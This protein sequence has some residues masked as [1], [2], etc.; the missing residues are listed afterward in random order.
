VAAI[1]QAN[2]LSLACRQIVVGEGSAA[3]LARQSAGRACACAGRHL[4]RLP[5]KPLCGVLCSLLLCASSL[6]AYSRL[7]CLSVSPTVPPFLAIS[8]LPAARTTSAAR[9]APRACTARCLR[10]LPLLAGLDLY[11]AGAPLTRLAAP[12]N[13]IRALLYTPRIHGQRGGN[14]SPHRGLTV[15]SLQR[16]ATWDA[17]FDSLPASLRARLV[18]WT[19]P[20][21]LPPGTGE[22]CSTCSH[23]NQCV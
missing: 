22:L 8:Q 5:Y 7:L 18:E 10:S 1:W 9:R 11:A 3:L 17:W 15:L 23:C 4:P 2:K 16:V 12:L 13:A 14:V 20:L 6:H 21:P 19:S